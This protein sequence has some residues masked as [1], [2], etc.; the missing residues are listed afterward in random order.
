VKIFPNL[1]R[2][3]RIKFQNLPLHAMIENNYLASAKKQFTQYKTLGEKAMEQVPDEKISW[4]FNPETN[5][6]ET[7]VKHLAGN[8][9]SRFTDFLTSDGEKQWRNRDAEFEPGRLNRDQLMARWNEGWDCLF[10]ALN[11]LSAAD[12]SKKIL[13]RNEEHSVMEAVNRQLTH[14]AY[15]VGQIVFIG[16]MVC[17][18]DWKSLSI[19]RGGSL[20]FNAEKGL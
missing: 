13:I 3:R 12:V 15:H 9:L 16:K 2:L 20:Q 4:Q 18:S 7:I 8:M 19:P 14:Y 11:D 17:D 10:N 5:S 1:I 6:M